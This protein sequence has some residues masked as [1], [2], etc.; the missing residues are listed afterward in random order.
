MAARDAVD[1]NEYFYS[2]KSQCPWSWAAWRRSQ[3]EIKPWQGRL[4]PLGQLQ[5]RVYT[6][7]LNPRRLKKLAG[8][9]DHG[10]DEIL[11]SHP[12][13]KKYSTPV[14]VLIQQDRQYLNQL[15]LGLA[16]SQ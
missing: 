1:W 12:R 16:N 3:I 10:A 9:L 15:R 13:Y 2:I 7:D 4:E 11:W 5:A 8:K 14:P 6:I